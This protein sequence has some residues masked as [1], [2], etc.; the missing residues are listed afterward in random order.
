LNNVDKKLPN[1]SGHDPKEKPNPTTFSNLRSQ[2]YLQNEQPQASSDYLEVK[3]CKDLNS[4][5]ISGMSTK[6]NTYTSDDF[7]L[8]NIT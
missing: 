5:G 4:K 7:K 3:V 8:K 2:N 1:V 6:V